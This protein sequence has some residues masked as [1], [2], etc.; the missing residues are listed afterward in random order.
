MIHQKILFKLL[1]V[2]MLSVMDY[3]ITRTAL[4]K[5]AIEANP[6]LAPIIE[7]PIGMTIK[8]MAPLIVLAYLWY[9]RNSNPFRVNYT[10]A[11]LVLFYSLVVTWN[12]SVYV[13]YLI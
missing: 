11:F 7:S 9:R 10:A 1:C 13:F 2:Y 5:G 8:L 4:A 6:I 12:V 3:I